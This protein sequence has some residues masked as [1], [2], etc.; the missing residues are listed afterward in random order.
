MI[1]DLTRHMAG[2]PHP[3]GSGK[4]PSLRG[5]LAREKYEDAADLVLALRHGE[6]YGYEDISSGGMA[7]IQA[8]LAKLPEGELA[9]IAEYLLSLK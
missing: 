6:E 9:A 2:G 7:A 3:D 4:V 1:E 8:N 5:L